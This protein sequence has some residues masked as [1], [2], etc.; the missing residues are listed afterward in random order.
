MTA[1]SHVTHSIRDTRSL[2]SHIQSGIQV[3]SC[4]TFNP[5]YPG[6]KFSH[7]THSIRDTRSLMSHIQSGIQGLSC[8]TF[9]PGYNVSH[10]THSIR[11]TRSLMSHIQSGIQGL[12][13]HTFNPGYKVSLRIRLG[14]EMHVSYKV[15]ACSHNESSS[16]LDSMWKNYTIPPG[17]MWHK[18]V[19]SKRLFHAL[20]LV[21]MKIRFKV[22]QKRKFIKSCSFP[23]KKAPLS[24]E[25]LS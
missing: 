13:C 14:F 24:C 17:G 20:S 12:S 7:V 1:I 8:H 10:V 5:G 3:L 2:M 4:H 21:F 11:D 22:E 16:Y 15:G 18:S 6:Y 23:Y 19:F 9:N 25:R